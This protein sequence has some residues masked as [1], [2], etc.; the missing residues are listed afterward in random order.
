M[1][2]TNPFDLSNLVI[3]SL[4]LLTEVQMVV[5]MRLAG[6]M[7]FWPVGMDEPH[8]M[9]SEKGPALMGAATHAHT[10]ALAGHRLDE[11]LIAAITPLTGTA[12]NNRV[13]LSAARAG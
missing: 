3:P 8:R 11:I 1:Q 2:P 4:D 10:A 13:R 6:M 12:R 9:I 5:S 7:G